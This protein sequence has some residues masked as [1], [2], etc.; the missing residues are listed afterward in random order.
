MLINRIKKFFFKENFNQKQI[1]SI[2]ASKNLISDQTIARK[3]ICF[4]VNG[5]IGLNPT[6]LNKFLG[7]KLKKKVFKDEPLYLKYIKN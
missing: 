4:K 2:V 3:D 6:S 5:G 7:K 1:K